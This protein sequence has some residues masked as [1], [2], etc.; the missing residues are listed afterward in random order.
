MNL[1][2]LQYELGILQILNQEGIKYEVLNELPAQYS[3][4]IIINRELSS[5]ELNIVKTLLKNRGAILIDAK[6][7]LKLIPG[8]FRKKKISYLVNDHTEIFSNILGIELEL[9]GY[10][11]K[12]QIFAT[13]YENGLI[14]ALP[15][16]IAEA[17]TDCR[18]FRK[19]FLSDLTKRYPNE[20]VAA[21]NKGALRTLIINSIRWLYQ[22]LN[23]PYIHLWYYPQQ[24]QSIFAV[25]I[26]TDFSGKDSIERTFELEN[27][28]ELKFTYF[29]H[30]Q[31]LFDLPQIPKDFQIHCYE[32]KVYPDYE[33]N[34]KNIFQA[35][36]ILESFGIN[37]IGFASPYGF[38]NKNLQRALE[39]NNIKYSS[40]FSLAY[41]DL[42]FYPIINNTLS[43]VLQIPVHPIC[44]GRLLHAGISPQNC[45]SYYF[46]Y[47]I[48]QLIKREPM[49]IYDHPNRVTQFYEVLYEIL[50]KAKGLPN[51]WLT[52]LTEYYYWWIKRLKI[53]N[54]ASW[55]IENDILNIKTSHTTADIALHIIFPNNEEAFI[56]LK[57]GSYNL[58]NLTKKKIIRL[59]FTDQDIRKYKNLHSF[60]TKTQISFFTLANK[61]LKY[62][63]RRKK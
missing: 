12:N 45:V 61:I 15:F 6:N 62:T 31:Y 30:T 21:I 32:H 55:T 7:L 50:H 41:D 17:V 53:F 16:N 60:Q 44:I 4:P 34:Y 56:T 35:K 2:I 20:I 28:T 25:R 27:K 39:D 14:V 48:T 19:P 9:P 1:G 51:I 47:F 8:K 54:E 33:R 11:N 37:P 18:S 22:K 43:C 24:Y 36:Q 10:I 5:S 40:E 38:W 42:P 13:E 3:D 59:D 57:N 63:K 52:T 46:N 26:D 23:R 29:I 49:I 58:K